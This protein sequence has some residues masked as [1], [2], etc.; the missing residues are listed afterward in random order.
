MARY[1][2][3]RS[4]HAPVAA[5]TA[6][7]VTLISRPVSVEL[8]NFD[9]TAVIFYRVDGTAATMSSDDTYRLGP[10]ETLQVDL[11]RDVEPPR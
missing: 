11:P 5:N 4:E 3:K 1:T 9:N 10:E 7:T 2:V 8:R 6:D